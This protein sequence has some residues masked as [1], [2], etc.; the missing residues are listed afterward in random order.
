MATPPVI[1]RANYNAM[2]QLHRQGVYPAEKWAILMTDP[3]FAAY[4][5]ARPVVADALNLKNPAPPT[6]V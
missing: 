6:P 3:E 5:A 4:V 2:L 1:D